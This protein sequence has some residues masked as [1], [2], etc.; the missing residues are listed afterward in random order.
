MGKR[1]PRKDLNPT[2]NISCTLY[3]VPR[4]TRIKNYQ[5][6]K[7]IKQISNKKTIMHEDECDSQSPPSKKERYYAHKITQNRHRKKATVVNTRT[8]AKLL[9]SGCAKGYAK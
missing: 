1:H 9:K 4:N 8:I 5:A 2:P 6:K 7:S 3:H